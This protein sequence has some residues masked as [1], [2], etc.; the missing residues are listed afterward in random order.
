MPLPVCGFFETFHVRVL[1][2]LERRKE[3]RKKLYGGVLAMCT[4]RTVSREERPSLASLWW[5]VSQKRK[6]AK[7]GTSHEGVR[8]TCCF[9]LIVCPSS[10]QSVVNH[11]TRQ[12]SVAAARVGGRHTSA[13]A[14][15]LITAALSGFMGII[16]KGCSIWIPISSRL[17]ITK[18]EMTVV[19]RLVILL[20][21]LPCKETGRVNSQNMSKRDV[22]L[23]YM[24]GMGEPL[25]RSH[26][27]YTRF[28]SSKFASRDLWLPGLR[29]PFL[30]S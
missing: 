27:P 13:S 1:I 3:R 6:S 14:T 4:S 26:M 23:V 19:R 28:S 17:H 8:L 10:L 29:L 24:G 16:L 22:C 21:P 18:V 5:W 2:V 12:S 30:A 25:I 7:A 9:L 15:S 20:I 11:S